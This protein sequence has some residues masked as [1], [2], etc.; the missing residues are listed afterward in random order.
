MHKRL[1]PIATT[2]AC[3]ALYSFSGCARNTLENPIDLNQSIHDVRFQDFGSSTKKDPA[4]FNPS[5]YQSAKSNSVPQTPAADSVV[6]QASVIKEVRVTGNNVLAERDILSRIRTRAGRYF[7]PDL[8]QQD[9]NELWKVKQIRRVKGPYIDR[10]NDGIVITIELVERP[11]I[12][13][14]RYIGNRALADRKLAEETGLAG[15]Q[16]LDLHSVKM[17]RTRLEDLYEEN[18]YPKTQVSIIEGDEIGDQNVTFLVHEDKLQRVSSV[19]FEGNQIATDGRLKSFIQIKPGFLKLFG[20]KVNRS[21]LKKTSYD[22][23][24]IIEDSVFSMPVSVAS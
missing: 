12:S 10:Q 5:T 23:S 17:A 3:I 9:V 21:Q 18:G 15:G 13:E 19:V 6:N 22:L 16:P 7:D 8:L 20:G 24:P 4:A 1:I 14:V 2:F 11:Y